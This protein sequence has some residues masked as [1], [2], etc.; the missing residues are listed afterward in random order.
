M[1]VL[2]GGQHVAR[3]SRLCNSVA[4][5]V[6]DHMKISC[7]A[8]QAL[9]THSQQNAPLRSTTT[10]TMRSFFAQQDHMQLYNFALSCLDVHVSQ[11]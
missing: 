7:Q 8:D 6:A 5:A 10:T 11:I 9:H 1:V 4:S 3:A 2:L